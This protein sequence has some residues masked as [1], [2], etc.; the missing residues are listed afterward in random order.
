MLAHCTASSAS[1][2]F[3]GC[4]FWFPLGSL[5]LVAFAWLLQQAVR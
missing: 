2:P 4:Y 1:Q 3:G 5:F